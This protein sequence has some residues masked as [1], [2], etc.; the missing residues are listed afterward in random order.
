MED[1]AWTVRGHFGGQCK[2]GAVWEEDWVRRV[3]NVGSDEGWRKAGVGRME[4]GKHDCGRVPHPLPG[5]PNLPVP[6]C[7][8]VCAG[9]L[10]RAPEGSTNPSMLEVM[11]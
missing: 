7:A 6:I 1:S 10:G 9:A 2:L 5:C 8:Y 4:L 3:V 11:G